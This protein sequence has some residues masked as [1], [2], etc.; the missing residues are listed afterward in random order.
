MGQ[1]IRERGKNQFPPIHVFLYDL[2][3]I[4]ITPNFYKNRTEFICYERQQFGGL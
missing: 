4:G 2:L 1:L 3:Q